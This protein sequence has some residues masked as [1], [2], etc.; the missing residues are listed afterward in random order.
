MSDISLDDSICIFE[1]DTNNDVLMTWCFPTIED[2]IRN[3]VLNR[4]GLKNDSVNA[5]FNFSKYKNSWIYLY[6]ISIP[7]QKDKDES[8]VIPDTLKKVVLFTICIIRN[9][10]NPEKY[11][12]LAQIMSNIYLKTG[13]PSKLLECHLRAVNRGQFDVGALGKFVDADYDIRRSYLATS[14]KDIIKLFDEQSILIWNAMMLKKRIVIYSDK[15]SP[16]LKVIRGFPLFVFHRQ[17]WSLLRP[18][19]TVDEDEIKELVNNG[20]Y[21]AGFT[22]PSIKSREDLYDL[23]VD[24]PSKEITV[25]SHAKDQFLLSSIHKDILKL[26]L[27]SIDEEVEEPMS[28]QAVMKALTIKVKELLVKL[29]SL[30]VEGDDGKSMVTLKSL[31]E[32]KL[33]PGMDTFLFNVANVEGLNNQ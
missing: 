33:P 25:A 13:D 27:T 32:R 24:L 2:S 4:S 21:V 26:L 7:A 5:Q 15:I 31:Q 17:N 23:L 28:D 10:Y 11:G 20:V 16:L 3:V 22:D 12:T 1:K 9:V 29:E 19:V 6:T 14:I 30:K 8:I 18:Y